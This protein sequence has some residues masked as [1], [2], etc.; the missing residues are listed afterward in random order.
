MKWGLTTWAE[1][2]DPATTRS[3]CHAWASSP[4][5]EF[6]RTVLGIDSDAPGFAR[7]KIEPRL[8][9]L[10]HASGSIPHP[11]GTIAVSYAMSGSVWRL[12]VT[13]PASVAGT[14]VWKGKRYPLK[15]GENVF[16]L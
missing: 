8:G 7:V 11:A 10:T 14:L 16:T 4:N 1:Y 3:D 6:F 15:G 9:A 5:I 12:R 2:S 13:L